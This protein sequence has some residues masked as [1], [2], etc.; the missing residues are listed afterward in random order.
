MTRSRTASRLSSVSSLRLP[1][2]QRPLSRLGVLDPISLRGFCATSSGDT[3]LSAEA[4]G[5]PLPREEHPVVSRSRV[6]RP[7]TEPWMEEAPDQLPLHIPE[8]VEVVQ[9]ADPDKPRLPIF[10]ERATVGSWVERTSNRATSSTSTIS[11]PGARL[12]ILVDQLEHDLRET[13]QGGGLDHLNRLFKSKCPEGRDQ[14]D[15]DMLLVILTKFLGRFISAKHFRQLL[16]RLHLSDKAVVT[17]QELCSRLEV[18]LPNGSGGRSGPVQGPGGQALRTAT[19]AHGLLRGQARSR[20]L[21]LVQSFLGKS[22]EGA[23]WITAAQLKNILE[24]LNLHTENREFDKLWK[25]YDEDGIGAVRLDAL[26]KKLGF[27]SRE[28]PG[29]DRSKN[30]PPGGDNTGSIMHCSPTLDLGQA[31][32]AGEEERQ[33]SITVETW[34]KDRFREG[35]Q[36]MKVEFDKLDPEKSGKVQPNSFLQVLRMF[37]L[38]LKG[39][40]LGLFLARC[41]LKVR[42]TG[43]DYLEFLRRFQDRGEEGVLHRIL[44]N[45][46]HRFHRS[47]SVSQGTSV[48]A[49]EAHLTRLFQSEYLA[50]LDIFQNLD[51]H[52]KK[53]VSQT[54]FRAALESRFR[55][56][57][58]DAQFEQLL[59]SLPLDADGNVQYLLF[60]AAFDTRGGAPSLFEPPLVEGSDPS[61]GGLEGRAPGWDQAQ[62]G[63]DRSSA[64]LFE[65]I[66]GLVRKDFPAVQAAYEQLDERNTR[67]MTQEDVCPSSPFRF[68]IRPEVS[69][70]E[71]RRL[72]AT[73]ITNQ[74]KTVDFLQFVRH[75]GHSPKSACFPNAKVC[76]PRAGDEDRRK[77]SRRL[78]CVSDI[79]VD[80]VRAKVELLCHQL[81]T[82]FRDQ[83]PYGTGFMSQEEFRRILKHLC[84]HLNEYECAVLARKFDI[85]ADGR[86][87]YVEF[88]KP[89]ASRG[90]K[91]MHKSNMAAVLQS[92]SD[93]EERPLRGIPQ[94]LRL[95]RKAEGHALRRAFRKL[96]SS[97]SGLLPSSEFNA[98]LKLRGATLNDEEM[99]HILARYGT[100]QDGCVDYRRFLLEECRQPP[101]SSS[102]ASDTPAT[103]HT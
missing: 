16:L 65:I 15:T 19:Q 12:R 71:V 51:K 98:V 20:F 26:L 70:G 45:P 2:I 96:D 9:A 29:A 46:K 5:R 39:K 52:G 92:Y 101:R 42:K 7:Q 23:G 95:S 64:E 24:Q 56:E 103:S 37:G 28:R 66:K 57:M 35:I 13:L 60:M 90:R 8:G 53:V 76:P 3:D 75:F 36:K 50:L 78:N 41:G 14:V 21:D 48:S 63:R 97:G 87:S 83:D 27:S 18:S 93:L 62:A 10:G 59:D 47:E 22:N 34:L 91:R 81:W 82:E 6:C 11:C 77:R 44:T 72:W 55:L 84:A 94:A 89:F 100:Q 67:R 25:R 38:H 30:D 68:D 86:V 79:L 49:V 73:L 85:N 80:A 33:A 1:A 74:D 102:V 31:L 32:Y 43:I 88:L 4:W 99:G 17:C 61:N 58:T 40:H 69:R 54:E